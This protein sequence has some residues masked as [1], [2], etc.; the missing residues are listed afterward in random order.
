MKIEKL[1]SGTYR[2]RK[3]IKGTSYSLLFDKRPTTKE[4][5]FEL[6]KLIVDPR[7]KRS[8]TFSDAA[9]SF[10]RDKSNVLSPSTLRGYRNNF[11]GLSEHFKNLTFDTMEQSDI[12]RE[13]NRLS[14]NLSAKTV[15]NYHGFISSVF[16]LYRPDFVL[17]T[18][19]PMRIE[20]EPYVPDSDKVKQLIERSKGT[21][22]EMCIMLGAFGMSR[23]EIC[24][25]NPEE[26]IDG[27]MAFIH[28]VLVQDMNNEWIIKDYTKTPKRTR[29]IWLP[30]HV[31]E[32]C[33][34]CGKYKGHPHTISDWM[35]RQEAE[36]GM[37]HFSLHKLR[38]YFASE[39]HAAG[40]PDRDIQEFGGWSTDHVMKRVYRHATKESQ[41]VSTK[42]AD[43][44]F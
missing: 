30:D 8:L 35:R 16:A 13:I 24:G 11:N 22:Y 1:P 25:F 14:Q 42:I 37:E 21:Q 12:Q 19:L 27:N 26:D 29:H 15:K 5:E 33:K 31:I 18:T 41:E 40:I 28:R 6:S 44:L 36:L 2:V 7:K 43:G 23:S 9:E 38:H 20:K 32:V 34:R 39:A 17:H 4:I 10:F 3:M